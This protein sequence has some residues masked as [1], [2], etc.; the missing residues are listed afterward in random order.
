MHRA[1]ERRSD[2]AEIREWLIQTFAYM[3]ERCSTGVRLIDPGP[4]K[5]ALEALY[6]QKPRLTA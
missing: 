1:L 6:P 2:I 3:F 5:E 4:D